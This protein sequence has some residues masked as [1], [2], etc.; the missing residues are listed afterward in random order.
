MR[1]LELYP[2]RF[3]DPVTGRWLRARYKASL[4]DLEQR[5]SGRYEI[6]GPPEI[7]EVD[8]EARYFNPLRDGR[9]ADDA[10]ASNVGQILIISRPLERQPRLLAVAGIAI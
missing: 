8:A 4:A 3:R 5:Y 10:S 9:R 7:R 6:T 1:R 2:F